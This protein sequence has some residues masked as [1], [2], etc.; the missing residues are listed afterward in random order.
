MGIILL[1]TL[2]FGFLSLLGSCDKKAPT[3]PAP[4]ATTLI[5]DTT[6]QPPIVVNDYA[7][8]WGLWYNGM[9]WG[10]ALATVNLLLNKDTTFAFTIITDSTQEIKRSYSG[11]YQE[12]AKGI[13]KVSTPTQDGFYTFALDT[14]LAFGGKER[15]HIRLEWR[16][17]LDLFGAT[18]PGTTSWL[19]TQY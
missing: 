2:A 19:L 10:S 14:V 15:I 6:T 18:S 3:S 7:E 5:V 1:T 4:P 8:L 16:S 13:L 17:G 11:N 12:S 9:Y